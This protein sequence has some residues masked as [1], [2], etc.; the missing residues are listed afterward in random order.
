LLILFGHF[1]AP[2]V[3]LLF[4]NVKRVP[5]LL[6]TIALWIIFMHVVDMYWLIF[7]TLMEH[8][9]HFGLV[10]L[11]SIGGGIVGIGGI[12]TWI[13]WRN[14]STQPVVPINDPKLNESIQF[15]NM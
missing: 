3:I 10:D 2:F 9:A 1:A 15:V 7:P 14:F 13:I 4:R 5:A 11:L 12:Y 8:G 6:S